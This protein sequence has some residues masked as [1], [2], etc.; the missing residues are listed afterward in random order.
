M[1]AAS[2]FTDR[3]LAG[4]TGR[5]HR[6]A[7]A[8][9]WEDATNLSCREPAKM[10]CKLPGE[11]LLLLPLEAYWGTLESHR[12]DFYRGRVLLKITEGE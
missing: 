4:V 5:T 11:T 6:E 9:G 10:T 3:K 1:K 2:K 7:T 8:W 12:K